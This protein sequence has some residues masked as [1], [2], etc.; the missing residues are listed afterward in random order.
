[1]ANTAQEE[2]DKRY[3]TSS[4]ITRTLNI[5]RSTLMDARRR[6]KLPNAIFVQGQI[7][8]WRREDV[9]RYLSA[10]STVLD[11]RRRQGVQ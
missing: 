1:M 7:Y 8:I 11:A 4:E 10:W 3:I 9:E 2:F 5:S 6:G